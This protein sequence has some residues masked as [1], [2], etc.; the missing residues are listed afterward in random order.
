LIF[1][2]TETLF[3]KKARQA[4]AKTYN[5]G[6]MLLYQGITAYELWTGTAV[7]K[8]VVEIVYDKL[9]AAMKGVG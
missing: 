5:G 3:L 9:D 6:K 8:E 2:P 7:N 1:N 4:G